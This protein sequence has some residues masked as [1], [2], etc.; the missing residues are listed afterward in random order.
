MA[1]IWFNKGFSNTLN[2]VQSLRETF[3][4]ETLR[5]I[6]TH[7]QEWFPSGTIADYAEREPI[8][9]DS[10]DYLA[11]A[12]E[13]CLTQKVDVFIPG[14]K[15]I[16]LAKSREDFE[17]Q[18]TRLLVAAGAE[19]LNLLESKETQYL[20]CPAD[21]PLPRWY[22]CRS[23]ASFEEA[24]ANLI[25]QGVQVCIK[26]A[27]SVFGLGFRTIV[28][29]GR[30]QQRLF[31]GDQTAIDLEDCRLALSESA[32]FRGLMV[33]ELLTGPE[34]SVDCLGHHG[35]LVSAVVRRKNTNDEPGQ[36]IEDHPE[37]V[38][39]CSILTAHF[40]LSGIY[41]IQFKE[42]ESGV[43]RL[44]EINPRMS[45]GLAMACAAGVNFPLWAIRL[46]LGTAQPKDVPRSLTGFRVCLVDGVVRQ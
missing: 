23:L 24:H 10:T 14:R 46:A 7:S 30:K 20:A 42:D 35:R 11:Y 37:I 12:L 9:I 21:V 18:G 38:H 3:P 6:C 34:R 32:S 33:M 28:G 13:F 15:M 45:G 5:V 2:A 25:S 26:P 16:C 1:N 27:V 43:S 19:T 41:N 22:C 29:P 39:L 4:G 17:R 8:K 40:A 44:L 36:W 31:S